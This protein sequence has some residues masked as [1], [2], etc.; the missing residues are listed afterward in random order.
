M[1]YFRAL[2]AVAAT[3]VTVAGLMGTGAATAAPGGAGAKAAPPTY[4]CV[5]T[6]DLLGVPVSATLPVPITTTV[7]NVPMYDGTPV[8]AGAAPLSA[9]LDLGALTDLDGMAVTS[10]IV[11]LIGFDG[12]LGGGLG[13]DAT[14]PLTIGSVPVTSSLSAAPEELD[15]LLDAGTLTGS[16]SLDPFTPQGT[17]L[18]DVSLP[19]TFDLVP[20]GTSGA[21]V[22]ALL[23]VTFAPVTCTSASGAPV[24]V[25]KVNVAAAGSTWTPVPGPGAPG[26]RGRA[27]HRLNIVGPKHARRGATLAFVASLPGG[28]G[29][30]VATIGRR[31]VGRAA[32]AGGAAR[33]RVHGLRQGT[34][35]ITF[36]AGQARASVTVRVR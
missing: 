1:K 10:A 13:F 18:Q 24:V 25:G 33:V 5:F 30:V 32:L 16:G 31:V 9:S 12:V 29:S 21:S 8:P 36:A 17:G 6:I 27:T 34:N 22:G 23:P 4:S 20:S 2:S 15:S 28:S 11:Q 35:R 7:P 19:A 3:A 14:H 26:S